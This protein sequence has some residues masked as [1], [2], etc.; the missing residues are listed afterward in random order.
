MIDTNS[1]NEI[2]NI[3]SSVEKKESVQVDPNNI[4]QVYGE[5]SKLVKSGQEVFENVKVL[6]ENNPG[7]PE[8]IGGAARML[9]SI[10]E[11]L[12][13]FTRVHLIELKH[14]QQMEMEMIKI[15][16]KREILNT[17]IQATKELQGGTNA[18]NVQMLAYNQEDMIKSI[19]AAEKLEK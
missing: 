19:L 3:E 4:E 14:K 17:K 18:S 2:F 9:D 15:G 5:L 16:G 7:D 13:E 8:L 12:K 11:T 6:V 1:L 10:R